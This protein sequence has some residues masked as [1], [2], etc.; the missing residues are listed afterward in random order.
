MSLPKLRTLAVLGL[1][2]G[3]VGLLAALP[4]APGPADKPA[5]KTPAAANPTTDVFGYSAAFDEELKKLGQIS[6]QEFARLFPSRA[7]YLRQA[8]LRPHEGEL[9]RRVQQGSSTLEEGLG[10][11][12][13]PQ[14]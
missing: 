14:H 1:L 8:Q 10:L 11:R 2:L 13:P 5:P 7:K 4:P 9:L 6:P 3:G 12:F